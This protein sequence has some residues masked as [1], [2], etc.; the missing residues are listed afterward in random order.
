[1]LEFGEIQ[2]QDLLKQPFRTRRATLKGKYEQITRASAY[3][4]IRILNLESCLQKT[5]LNTPGVKFNLQIMD[6]V[7]TYL[8]EG[9]NWQGISGHY[10]IKLGSESSATEGESKSLP[11]LKASVNA[12][13]RMWFGVRPASSLALTD[14][15]QGKET[16]LQSLDHSLRLPIPHPGWDF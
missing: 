1:M 14:Q 6:P 9:C 4:Q 7:S 3:W 2:L 8:D 13:S 16:L 10:I 15:L 12:F 5:H 11:T